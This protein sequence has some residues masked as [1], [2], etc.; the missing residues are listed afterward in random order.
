MALIVYVLSIPNFLVSSDDFTSYYNN[1]VNMNHGDVGIAFDEFGLEFGL[2]LI[3]YFLTFVIDGNYPYIFKFWH[4]LLN[5]S[6]LIFLLIY[7]SSKKKLNKKEMLLLFSFVFILYKLPQ[8]LHLMR[9]GYASYFVLFALFS[10][11]KSSRCLFLLIGSL[12]HLSTVVIFPFLWLM[13]KVESLKSVF[14]YSF[15][16]LLMSF[17]FF[18]ISKMGLF[19]NVPLL[20]KFNFILGYL[21]S[22]E[23]IDRTVSEVLKALLY[24][25][26]LIFLSIYYR[27]K[28]KTTTNES[29]FILVSLSF[30]LAFSM[31]PGLGMRVYMPIFSIFLGYYYFSLIKNQPVAVK[32]SCLAFLFLMLNVN[33]VFNSELFY[34]QYPMYSLE[35]FYYLDVWQEE[36]DLIC[37]ECLPYFY[38]IDNK[39]K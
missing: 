24:F 28:N 14:K 8:Q 30:L 16:F 15:A 26:P 12:F 3:N 11:K 19:F 18:S 20:S 22:D 4:S 36:K 23:H 2:P 1:F 13:F 37:R 32:L 33:W 31:F 21:G 17:V 25:Y 35:P 29:C 5:I 9:Q 39:Y 7:V 6:M 38:E 27:W 34:Y 10:E